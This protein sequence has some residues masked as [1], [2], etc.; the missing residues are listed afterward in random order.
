MT[1]PWPWSAP[2]LSTGSRI[3]ALLDKALGAFRTLEMP[4]WE[5]RTLALQEK[6]AASPAPRTSRPA[7]PDGLTAREVEV[8]RLLAEG[9]TNKEIAERLVLSVP[10]VSRH[11]ATIYNKIDARNRADATAY[12]L[13]HGPALGIRS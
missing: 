11:I 10:T 7:Y 9:L 4:D 3:D 6:L 12:A 1:R 8:L 2:D 5:Q 13:R